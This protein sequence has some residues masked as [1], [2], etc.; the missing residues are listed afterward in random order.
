MDLSFSFFVNPPPRMLFP[1]IFG[2]CGRERESCR[3]ARPDALWF[4][5]SPNGQAGLRAGGADVESG[6][7]VSEERPSLSAAAPMLTLLP[8]P[9]SLAQAPSS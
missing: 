2:G 7:P 9:A 5:L 4:L 1:L 3:L 6:R 8:L